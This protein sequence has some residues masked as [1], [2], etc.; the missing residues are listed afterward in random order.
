MKT[1]KNRREDR[2]G[3]ILD[4][5]NLIDIHVAIEHSLWTE[6]MLAIEYMQKGFRNIAMSHYKR[7]KELK[8]ILHSIYHAEGNYVGKWRRIHYFD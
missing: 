1:K 2:R 8:N 5:E 7:W 3:V 6:R 4:I